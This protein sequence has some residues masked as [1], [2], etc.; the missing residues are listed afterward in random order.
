MVLREQKN[1]H[2]LRKTKKNNR[3]NPPQNIIRRNIGGSKREIDRLI[4]GKTPHEDAECQEKK[5]KITDTLS[6]MKINNR[7][8]KESRDRDHDGDDK[9]RIHTDSIVRL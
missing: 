1:Q 5:N 2:R 6:M 7:A 4:I 3:S 9:I 8:N